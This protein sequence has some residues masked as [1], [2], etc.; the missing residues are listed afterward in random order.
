MRSNPTTDDELADD[1]RRFIENIASHYAPP[2]MGP[3]QRAV[4]RQRLDERL[5]QR[6]RWP[7]QWAIAVSATAVAA[8]VFWLNVPTT[9]RPTTRPQVAVQGQVD[10][11]VLYAYVDPDLY[12]DSWRFD[13][14]LPDDYQALAV[15]M[16]VSTIDR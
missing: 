4:F 13:S 6:T 3:Q 1:D 9:T 7:W 10:A 5:Q 2:A 12:D 8:A 15:A 14:S 16:D 11:P